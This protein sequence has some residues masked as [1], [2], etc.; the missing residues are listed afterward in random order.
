MSS[1]QPVRD[2]RQQALTRRPVSPLR[3]RTWA[4]WP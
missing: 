1:E 2:I 4:D 3:H